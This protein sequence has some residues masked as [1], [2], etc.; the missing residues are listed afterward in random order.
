MDKRLIIG[1][2]LAGGVYYAYKKGLFAGKDGGQTITSNTPPSDVDTEIA[3]AQAE[4]TAKQQ[5][6]AAVLKN[7]ASVVSI[8]NASSYKDKVGKIQSALG[9]PIDGDAGTITNGAFDRVYGLSKGVISPSNV[10]FYLSLVNSNMTK[11]KQAAVASKQ[12]NAQLTANAINKGGTLKVLKGGNFNVYNKNKAT[13]QWIPNGNYWTFNTGYVF[14]TG[15][16]AIAFTATDILLT[17][18]GVAFG[19]IPASSLIIL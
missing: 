16:K 12:N 1:A 17:K 13:N 3:K 18:N 14:G 5:V 4:T 15:W 10:D 7:A 11:I 6:A 9:V 19:R 2:A 8:A